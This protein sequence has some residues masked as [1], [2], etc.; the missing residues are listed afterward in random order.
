M[1]PR[2]TASLCPSAPATAGAALIG[3]VQ[4]DGH[5][6]N[7]PTSLPVDRGFIDRARALGP[8]ERRFRFAAPCEKRRCEHWAGDACGL[9]GRLLDAA[10]VHE[11][12]AA[13]PPPCAIRA[14]CRWWDQEGPAACAVC[15]LVVTDVRAESLTT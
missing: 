2:E 1:I 15:T 9:I 7:L 6:A 8:L 4:P 14:I 13:R 5:V 12:L 11:P 10:E 3:I